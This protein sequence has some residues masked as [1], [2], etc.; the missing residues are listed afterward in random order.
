M[1]ITSLHGPKVLEHSSEECLFQLTVKAAP[2]AMLIVDAE[3]K[4]ELTND[5]AEALFG[6]SSTEL[7]GQHIETLIPSRYRPI[8]DDRFSRS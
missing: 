8:F 3:K 6:Y 1:R 2:C 5:R 7:A 4:I